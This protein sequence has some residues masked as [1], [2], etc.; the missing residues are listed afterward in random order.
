MDLDFQL[1]DLWRFNDGQLPP[2]HRVIVAAQSAILESASH[3]VE[4]KHGPLSTGFSGLT[5]VPA[6]RRF[7]A[8]NHRG[9]GGQ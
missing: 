6:C 9:V 5:S 3:V 4:S 7:V 1:D 8:Q 2:R